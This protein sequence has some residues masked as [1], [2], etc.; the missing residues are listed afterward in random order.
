[1]PVI[2]PIGWLRDLGPFALV[3]LDTVLE[4]AHH[5]WL[6]DEGFEF[7]D[8][9]LTDLNGHP[10]IVATHLPWLHCGI[11]FMDA[12]NLRNG[13]ALIERLNGYKGTAKMIS[14]HVHRA[15]TGQI[16]NVCCQIGP[17]T[18]HAVHRDLR[19]DAVHALALEPGGVTLHIWLGAPQQTFISDLLP[20]TVKPGVWPFG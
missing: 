9:T 16:G 3:G 8:R 10:L 12:N 13:A 6:S 5:G 1:M 14:G 4:G 15:I 19:A 11:P 17:S 7:L 2:G 18:G 20:I